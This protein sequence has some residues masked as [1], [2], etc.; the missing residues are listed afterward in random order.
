M[1]PKLIVI[2]AG[3]FVALIG[4]VCLA[5]DQ[6]AVLRLP[7]AF[8]ALGLERIV[9]GLALM[10]LGF[11]GALSEVWGETP[12]RRRAQAFAFADGVAAD[13]CEAAADGPRPAGLVLSDP[14]PEVAQP[15]PEPDTRPEPKT[16]TAA[17][18]APPEP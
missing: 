2:A 6:F 1:D 16:P 4:Y 10:L 14:E 5:P 3:L 15:V 9:T 13:D 7:P 11:I 17:I 18:E 12:K 8:T